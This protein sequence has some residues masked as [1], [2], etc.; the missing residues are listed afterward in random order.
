M[1]ELDV[2]PS[3]PFFYQVRQF[4]QVLKIDF[5]S[6]SCTGENSNGYKLA[7]FNNLSQS[8]LRI[9]ELSDNLIVSLNLRIFLIS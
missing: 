3:Q 8:N 7:K 2:F 1:D 9:L 5:N 4:H 6:M